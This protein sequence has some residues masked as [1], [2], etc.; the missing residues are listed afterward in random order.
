MCPSLFNGQDCSFK[1]ISGR[2]FTGCPSCIN[3]NIDDEGKQNVS[4][5]DPKDLMVHKAML[6]MNLIS[7][8][9]CIFD[10]PNGEGQT[11]EQ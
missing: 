11:R 5:S 2:P 9:F 8:V 1:T 6:T 4:V 3:M 10:I 7:S